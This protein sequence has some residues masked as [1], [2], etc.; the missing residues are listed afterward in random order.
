VADNAIVGRRAELARLD[1]HLAGGGPTLLVVVGEAGIGKTRLVDEVAARHGSGRRVVRGR[2][3]EHEPAAFGLWLGVLNQLELPRPGTDRSVPAGELR[4]DVVDQLTSGLRASGPV[5]AVLDDLHWADDYSLWVAEQVVDRVAGDDVVI[6]ATTRPAAEA[7]SVRWPA[8]HR[9]AEVLAL[10]GLDVEEVG[11]LAERVGGSSVDAE[12]LWRRTGGNP[13]FVRELAVSDADAAPTATVVL[14]ASIERAGAEVADLVTLVAAAGPGT[15]RDVLAYAAGRS[16]DELEGLVEAAARS[17]FVRIGDEGIGLRHD[18]LVSA[19]LGRLAPGDRRR[20][21]ESLAGAWDVVDGP[22][23]AAA[24]A[25]HRLL[26]VPAVDPSAAGFEVLAAAEALIAGGRTADAATLLRLASTTLARSVGVD[27]TLC[28]RLAV[29]ESAARYA[30]G[31]FDAAIEVGGIAVTHAAH[32]DDPVLAAAAEVTAL[33]HHNPMVPDPA[34]VERLADIDRALPAAHDLAD[35]ALRIRLRGRRAVLLM[36]LPD[37]FDEAHALGDDA[38][39]R[40]RA[41][42][43]PDLL[44][45]ALADRFFVLTTPDDYDCR[46]QAADELVELGRS[47]GRLE[48][49]RWGREWQH[50]AR[51]ANGDLDG[52]VQSLAELE[53]VAAVLPSPYWRYS[54]ALRRCGMVASSGDYE[55]ALALIGETAEL[56]AG[57]V[58]EQERIG[59]DAG[60]RL[61]TAMVYGRADHGAEELQARFV[62]AAGAVPVL[63]LQARIA[64]GEIMLGDPAAARTRLLP[65]SGRLDAGL[66][67]PEGLPTLGALA[68]AAVLL[69][70]SAAAAELRTA[71][72]PFAGRLVIGNGV[73][74][75]VSVD[76]HLAALALLDGDLHAAV[77]HAQAAVAFARRFRAPVIEARAL[78]LLAEV[79]DRTGD[80]AAARSARD[81]AIAIAEPIGMH[82]DATG[83]T[84]AGPAA[85]ASPPSARS[86]D[87]RAVRLRLDN[88]RWFI[89]SR[90]GSGH[91]AASTGMS[92]LLRLLSAP[93]TDVAAVDLAVAARGIAVVSSDLGPA[94]DARAKREYRRRIN[95]LQ[96]DIDEA[97]THHDL[98]RATKHRVEL[99]AILGELRAAVGLGGRDRLR[100][101]GNERARI[102]AA[103]TIRRAVAAIGTALP[104]LGAH[105]DVSVRTGHHCTYA[106]EPAAALTW[107][108]EA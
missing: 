92:Q 32:A 95:E 86:I 17:D 63:F 21:H 69:D 46:A 13:L 7:R 67:G 70:W 47:T 12:R 104:D 65:W 38:V 83:G 80:T 87:D 85:T 96:A 4:W 58:P 64:L 66:R 94:L 55:G 88:G 33:A 48:I 8:L 23:S 2:A 41:T 11:A 78:A 52:A 34:R 61:S 97:E 3:D 59:L 26:A 68:H 101:S 103:R 82:L 62:D 27:R 29:A 84:S 76:H 107:H 15:P 25:R 19:A 57:V 72:A 35:P 9:R 106:P 79:T 100:G 22:E 71:L 81:A 73:M 75:D 105:L 16:R 91:V 40:A 37:R 108:V 6:L 102:N 42:G 98:E 45:R 53:A 50:A 36:S 99:D 10:G 1:A 74:L 56:G 31:D 5:L 51:L 77:G 43:D 60:L 54:A 90:F 30:L 44:V 24:A 14:A 20:L 93:G 39:E 49:V 89:E 28:A 18:L